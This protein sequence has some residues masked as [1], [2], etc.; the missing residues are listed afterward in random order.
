[1]RRFAL[2]FA[3]AIFASF[4]WSSAA[5]AGG[6]SLNNIWTSDVADEGTFEWDLY[7]AVSDTEFAGGYFQEDGRFLSQ[8]FFAG[9][10]PD[11]EI[12]M[13]FNAERE[14]GPFTMY[15]KYQVFDE[16]E[17]D[18]PV[19]LAVGVDNIVGTHDRFISE[20]IPYI[21]IGKNFDRANGYLGFAHNASGL[22]DDNSLFGGF[23]YAWTD[24]WT[25]MV[26]YYGYFDNE[27]SVIAGGLYY[28]WI[29]HIDWGAFASYDSATENTII[30]FNFIFTGRFDDLEAEV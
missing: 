16:M 13:S 20:P 28:D 1:M 9:I 23:D 18:F 2:I 14:I 17:D 11:F 6:T 10:L 19:S 21:V 12:G 30:V 24:E 26:D 7:L 15:C 3:L 25:I 5:L 4:L 8:E 29:N 22:E 27:E